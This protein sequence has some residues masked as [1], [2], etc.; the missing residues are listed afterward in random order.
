MV[1]ESEIGRAVADFQ[2]GKD[3]ERQFRRIFER[4]YAPVRAFLS[5]RASPED[6]VDLTQETFLRLYTGLKGY[7]GDAA[8]STWVFRIAYN[9]WYQW[10]RGRRRRPE[11][12]YEDLGDDAFRESILEQ[13]GSL[14]SDDGTD[15]VD[16]LVSEERRDALRDAVDELPDQMR[17]CMRLRLYQERPYRE[18]AEILCISV[19]TVKAHLFQGRKRLQ[20]LLAGHASEERP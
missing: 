4:F 15:P 2:A 8:F 14:T 12:S 3:P 7:R 6:A 9:T 5:R 19:E 16:F 17:R 20:E 10:S 18:I 13:R 1:E 11:S